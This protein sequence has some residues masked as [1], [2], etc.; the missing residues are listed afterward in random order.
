MDSAFPIIDFAGVAQGD[1]PALGRAAR[2][3]ADACTRT[4]FFY[5]VNHGLPEDV[6]A[7][8]VN[9]AKKFFA[10]PDDVKQRS[11]AVDHRG[12]IGIGDAFMKNAARSDWKESFVVGLELPASDP[13]VVAGE[14]L[15]G[16]NVWPQAL[17]EFRAALT[18][19]YAAAG[20]CGA[21]LLSAFAV[22]LGQ[23]PDFFASLYTKPLQRMNVIHYPPHPDGAPS[24][25]F[26]GAARTDYGCVTLWWQDDN[27]GL[28]IQTRDG[29]WIAAPPLAGALVINV[30]DL[31]QRWSGGRYVSNAHRV[32]NRSGRDRYSIATFY[33][34][35]YQALVDPAAFGLKGDAPV[36]AGDYILGRVRG[37]FNYRAV[38]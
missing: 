37:S 35:N 4:G 24:D 34:P 8:A 3:I 2:Q 13:D 32:T 12:Y 31:L 10:Q 38:V 28:E 36:R 25:Q 14:A 7:G 11:N 19:Y 22:S 27:G 29:D 17:P 18:A 30:G 16:P 26:G 5:V 33:D 23:A 15:R 21:N 6:I 1:A 20:R 9:A